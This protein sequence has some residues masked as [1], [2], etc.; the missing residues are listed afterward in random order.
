MEWKLYSIPDYER[1][2]EVMQHKILVDARNIWPQETALK[3][4]FVCHAIG[5]PTVGA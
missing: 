1:L 3:H 4:D 5:R 2:A